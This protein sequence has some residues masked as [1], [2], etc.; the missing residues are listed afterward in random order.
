VTLTLTAVDRNG[1]GKEIERHFAVTWR[2]RFAGGRWRAEHAAARP[3][4]PPPSAQIA[5]C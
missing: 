3:L 1:C 4:E 5:A 2:L